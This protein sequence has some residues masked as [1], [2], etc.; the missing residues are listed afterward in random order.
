MSKSGCELHWAANPKYKEKERLGFHLPLS[1][2]LVNSYG[3]G[4][5]FGFFFCCCCI[6][7]ALYL[8]TERQRVSDAGCAVL[9][10]E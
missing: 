4:G 9:Q 8:S 3:G 5:D 2:F 1:S 10:S 6:Y 7:T